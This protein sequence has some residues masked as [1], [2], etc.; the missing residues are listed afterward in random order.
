MNS[1]RPPRLTNNLVDKIR[2][3]ESGTA[4]SAPDKRATPFVR[5]AHRFESRSFRF[6]KDNNVERRSR[7]DRIPKFND[8]ENQ[9]F[10]L[11]QARNFP[12]G[13]FVR[14]DQETLGCAGASRSRRSRTG[15]EAAAVN[16][17]GLIS[18]R[19]HR[20]NEPIDQD[21]VLESHAKFSAKPT[22]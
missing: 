12:V 3:P 13:R 19:P 17:E 5:G 18:R 20:L 8:R 9:P 14:Q 1:E 7:P 21:V 11:A 6:P 2:A 22:A 16:P 10:Q 15:F 4:W